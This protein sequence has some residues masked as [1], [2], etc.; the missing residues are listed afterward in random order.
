MEQQDIID[1]ESLRRQK[2]RAFDSALESLYSHYFSYLE[3]NANIR[4]KV[5]AK[6]I[7]KSAVGIKEEEFDKE[8]DEHFNHWFAFDYRNIQG[9]NMFDLFFKQKKNTLTQPMLVLSALLMATVLEPFKVKE[10]KSSREIKVKSLIT[11]QVETIDSFC[12]SFKNIQRDQIVL[13]RKIKSGF[14]YVTLSPPVGITEEKNPD[15]ERIIQQEYGSFKEQ[16]PTATAVG[17]L[18]SNTLKFLSQVF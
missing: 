2:Q 10:K 5:R 6:H 1:I 3:R 11:E 17:F 12:Y 8:L 9:T 4:E 13:L 7:F 14:R 18:K 15:L 16:Y